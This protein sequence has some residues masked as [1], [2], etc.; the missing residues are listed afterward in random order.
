MRS[1]RKVQRDLNL[2]FRQETASDQ[3]LKPLLLSRCREPNV[4]EGDELHKPNFELTV[5]R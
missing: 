2:I 1:L 4:R 5:P 3:Q